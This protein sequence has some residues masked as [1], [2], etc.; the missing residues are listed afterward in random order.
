PE[1]GPRTARPPPAARRAQERPADSD[2]SYRV[3]PPRG[4]SCRPPGIPRRPS[5]RVILRFASAK[6]VPCASGRSLPARPTLPQHAAQ[7]EHHVRGPP[8]QPPHEVG[9]LLLPARDVL[10]APVPSVAEARLEIPPDPV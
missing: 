9:V 3:F 8:V 6:G 5:W 2:G 4:C 1:P 10:P 7:D